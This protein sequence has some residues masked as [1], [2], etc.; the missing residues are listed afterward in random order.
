MIRRCLLF[1]ARRT[2]LQG[3]E[4]QQRAANH[5]R[6]QKELH[7]NNRPRPDHRPRPSGI[8][9]PTVYVT[10]QPTPNSKPPADL[11]PAKIGGADAQLIP[12]EIGDARMNCIQAAGKAGV[13]I[14]HYC[15]HPALTVVASCRMC[16]VEV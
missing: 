1:L 9:M 8:D 5:R 4:K 6:T 3:N 13:F 7:P 16:L 15:W 10:Y 11:V 12:V 2:A 14:P